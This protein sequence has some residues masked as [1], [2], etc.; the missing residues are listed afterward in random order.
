M[1]PCAVSIVSILIIPG[2]RQSRCCGCASF[3]ITIGSPSYFD[4]QNCN[5]RLLTFPKFLNL[6]VTTVKVD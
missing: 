3:T 5:S 2:S 4:T 1:F 6:S